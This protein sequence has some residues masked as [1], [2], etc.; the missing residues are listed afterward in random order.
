LFDL[1]FRTFRAEVRP[2][3]LQIFTSW[4]LTK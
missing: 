2:H 3:P 4:P 1:P